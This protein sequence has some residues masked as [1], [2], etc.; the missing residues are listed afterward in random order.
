LLFYLPPPSELHREGILEVR[1]WLCLPKAQHNDV[2]S[3]IFSDPAPST[4][5]LYHWGDAMFIFR[6][7]DFF[8]SIEK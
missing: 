7:N 3:E 8:L 1:I 6:S 2:I 4:T 5:N